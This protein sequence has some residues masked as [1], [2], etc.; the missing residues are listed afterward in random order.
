M[1][2][3]KKRPMPMTDALKQAIAESGMSLNAIEKATGIKRA[4]LSRFMLGQTS[5]HLD[6][7][8]TLAV[9]FG[10]T[11]SQRKGK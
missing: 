3:A 4:S 10:L 2:K 6:L 11:V 8:D 5:L 9:Y 1:G 7:A